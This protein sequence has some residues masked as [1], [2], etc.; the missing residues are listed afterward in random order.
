[1]GDTEEFV[2]EGAMAQCDKS[3]V[4]MVAKLS[5]I[6]DNM[7]SQTNGK[8]EATTMTLGPAF[9]VQPFGICNMI[10]PTPAMPTPPC[11]C[12]IA[13]WSGAYNKRAI[14]PLNSNPLTTNSKGTCVLGGSISFKTSGQMAKVDVV[15]VDSLSSSNISPIGENAIDNNVK[16]RVP[17]TVDLGEAK[18]LFNSKRTTLSQ[19]NAILTQVSM[20]MSFF[21]QNISNNDYDPDASLKRRQD[22]LRNKNKKNLKANIEEGIDEVKRYDNAFEEFFGEYS[23]AYG[24][25]G[26]LSTF[27]TLIAFQ[28]A[29]AIKQIEVTNISVILG[30]LQVGTA[31]QIGA[32]WVLR[33]LACD[34][35]PGSKITFEEKIDTGSGERHIDAVILSKGET[36]HVEYKSVQGVPPE[37]FTKQ[38]QKDMLIAS[39]KEVKVNWKFDGDKLSK[40]YKKSNPDAWEGDKSWKELSDDEKELVRSDFREK[41]RYGSEDGDEMKGGVVNVEMND[42]LLEDF[43][44]N[45]MVF[46]KTFIIA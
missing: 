16:V 37:H 1:M 20:A 15:T 46:D 41:M 23:F 14:M 3:K 11:V 9:G 18:D 38:F 25:V 35:E 8:K 21:L 26:A 27:T 33:N 31:K 28:Y 6:L 40:Q 42:D 12:V 29:I 17:E 44:Y 19:N 36:T 13:S 32:E 39:Q 2:V 34:A 43:L 45:D 4:P 7:V 10:P 30:E 22:A 24:S 5:Y